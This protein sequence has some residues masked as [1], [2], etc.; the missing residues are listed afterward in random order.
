M[1]NPTKQRPVTVKDIAEDNAVFKASQE[2][3][4]LR[5]RTRLNQLALEDARKLQAKELKEH[6][7]TLRGITH[8]ITLQKSVLKSLKADIREN[9]RVLTEQEKQI[10]EA[11]SNGNAHILDL[12]H[13]AMNSEEIKNRLDYEVAHLSNEKNQL[14]KVS[15]EL[16]S[17]L[18]LLDDRYKKQNDIYQKTLAEL[19]E[20]ILSANAELKTIQAQ[21]K[22]ILLKL[23]DKEKSLKGKELALSK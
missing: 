10:G 4:Q 5:G 22:D 7:E 3:E 8:E 12:Q 17:R 21:S 13:E 2:L 19:K 1:S 9:K 11:V 15:T 6:E 20:R 23:M 14:I 16:G 18:T